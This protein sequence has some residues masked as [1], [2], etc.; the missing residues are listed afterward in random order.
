MS[1]L[2]IALVGTAVIWLVAEFLWINPYFLAYFNE[3]AGGPAKGVHYVVD[4]NLDWG[5]D[6]KRLRDFV[7]KNGIT[8]IKVDYFGGGNAEYYLGE[9]YER[10]ERGPQKGWIAVSASFLKS[11][12]GKLNLGLEDEE[13]FYLWLNA[14]KPVAKIGYSIYVY[15][16]PE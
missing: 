1:T 9:R 12:Q 6:L 16:I 4:S 11:G 8:K 10:L 15:R 2:K 14:Y 13:G 7:L 5:Q 3:F